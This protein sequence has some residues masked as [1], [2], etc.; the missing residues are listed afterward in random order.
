M[1]LISRIYKS[2]ESSLITEFENIYKPILTQNCVL[3]QFGVVEN[4]AQTAPN[5]VS[6]QAIVNKTTL[7]VG[8][9]ANIKNL[10]VNYLPKVSNEIKTEVYTKTQMMNLSIIKA[11]SFCNNGLV[12]TCEMQMFLQAN[13]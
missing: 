11:K 9:I 13:S 7:R 3:Y 5:M 12:A 2:D 10:V 1:I 4:M 6:Y 8:F